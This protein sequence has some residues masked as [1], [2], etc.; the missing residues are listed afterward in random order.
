[1]RPVGIDRRPAAV[2]GAAPADQPRCVGSWRSR[3]I[4]DGGDDGQGATTPRG[5]VR[6]GAHGVEFRHAFNR[7]IDLIEHQT[8]QIDVEIG[9]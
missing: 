9:G 2:L 8:V 5:S 3:G 6:W 1:M 7:A 4:F